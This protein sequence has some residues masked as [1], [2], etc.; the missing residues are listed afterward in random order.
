MGDIPAGCRVEVFVNQTRLEVMPEDSAACAA[1]PGVMD[2][3]A[4]GV[5]DYCVSEPNS[6]K[7]SF[8]YSPD[9]RCA[10]ILA[11]A[12]DMVLGPFYD[13]QWA[14][15]RR[16]ILAEPDP[17]QTEGISF[18]FIARDGAVVKVLAPRVEVRG[19]RLFV[20]DIIT[21]VAPS[22]TIKLGANVMSGL[23]DAV[24]Y[25]EEMRHIMLPRP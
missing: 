16:T 11:E 2:D 25:M 4:D 14:V 24:I 9:A 8:K 7:S 5:A 17:H 22:I 15:M 12:R 1:V 3:N 19:D 23:I 18:S 6:P 20:D 21:I 10:H 13:F